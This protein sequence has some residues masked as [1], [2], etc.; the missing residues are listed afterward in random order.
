MVLNRRTRICWAFTSG[1]S[2]RSVGIS[3]YSTTHAGIQLRIFL[4]DIGFCQTDRFID[5]Y[6]RYN[7]PARYHTSGPSFKA[8]RTPILY[9]KVPLVFVLKRQDMVAY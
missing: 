4:H 9:E 5:L 1:F 8:S 7:S 6:Y 3:M 2:I